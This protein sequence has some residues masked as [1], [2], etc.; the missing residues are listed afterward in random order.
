MHRE[1]E[2]GGGVHRKKRYEA[3]LRDGEQKCEGERGMG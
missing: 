3:F 2:G 1:E